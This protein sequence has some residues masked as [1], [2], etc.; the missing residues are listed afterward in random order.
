MLEI[1]TNSV[2]YGS[3]HGWASPLLWGL[4]DWLDDPFTII[5]KNCGFQMVNGIQKKLCRRNHVFGRLTQAEFN[6]NPH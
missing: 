5:S 1:I 4:G 2:D 6:W 3:F